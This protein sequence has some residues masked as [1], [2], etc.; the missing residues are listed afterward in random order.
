MMCKRSTESSERR[1]RYVRNLHR[2]A[3]KQSRVR[4]HILRRVRG[5]EQEKH[6]DQKDDFADESCLHWNQ[7][8]LRDRDSYS[9][10][11]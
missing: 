4:R 5:V 9:Q 6:S 10:E 2:C 1:D 11:R 3:V 8:N 7:Q